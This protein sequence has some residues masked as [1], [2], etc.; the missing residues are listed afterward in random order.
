MQNIMYTNGPWLPFNQNLILKRVS[1]LKSIAISQNLLLGSILSLR[2]SPFP[3]LRPPAPLI[4]FSGRA[5][6]QSAHA[7]AQRWIKPLERANM[8]GRT[9]EYAEACAECGLR[10]GPH[11]KA[12]GEIPIMR[13]SL[14]SRNF[15]SFLFFNKF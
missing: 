11:T 1:R 3:L 2:H 12:A 14:Y 7:S 5:M 10:H 8:N 9:G 13:I 6:P 4:Q 15:R